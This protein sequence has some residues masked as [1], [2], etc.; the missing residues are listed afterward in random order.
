MAYFQTKN[1]NL[2]TFWR[3]LQWEMRVYF[4]TVWSILRPFGI[5]VA[6]W[7]ILWLFGTYIFSRFGKLYQE[8]SGNPELDST[9]DLTE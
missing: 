2:G 8:K 9:K 7:C 3:V 1:P 6:V 5:F 4:M